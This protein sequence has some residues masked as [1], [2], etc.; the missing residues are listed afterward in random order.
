MDEMRRCPVVLTR[1][2]DWRAEQILVFEALNESDYMANLHLLL[3]SRDRE[4]RVRIGVFPGFP[5]RLA[6]PLAVA[7]GGTLFLERTPGRFKATVGGGNL[8]FAELAE[9]RIDCEDVARD[10]IAITAVA[11]HDTMPDDYPMPAEPLVDELHQWRQRDWPGKASSLGEVRQGLHAELAGSEPAWPGDWSVYGGWQGRKFEATG[12]FRTEHDGRRWWLVDPDGNAFWSAGVDCVRMQ[13]EVNAN[14]LESLFEPPLP[15]RES[16]PELWAGRGFDALSHNLSRTLPDNWQASW[17]E[18]TRRR[19]I[20]FGFNTIGNWS[21]RE[22]QRTAKLPYVFT[23]ADFPSTAQPLFRDFPDVYSEEYTTNCA[24][25]A[26]QLA[27]IRDD[28]HVIGY[29]MTNEPKWAFLTDFD[30]GRQLLLDA[31]PS[32]TRDAFVAFLKAR[33]AGIAEL[34]AAWGCTLSAWDDL[35]RPLDLRPC[36]KSAKDTLA[37][38]HEAVTEYVTRPAAACHGVDPHH[39]NLGLRWA[40]IHHDYQLAGCEVLDLFS[41][42][43]YQLAPPAETIAEL[44]RQTGKPV[45]IG[46]WHIGALDRGLPSGGIRNCA[47]MDESVAAYRYYLEQAA[48]IPELVGAHYFQ[49]TDQH[50]L[51]RFD[52][53]NMQIGLHDITYRPYA[54]HLAALPDIHARAY[55]IAAGQAEPCD[56]PPVTVPWGTLVG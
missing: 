43:C 38:T 28:R 6:I 8:P 21:D 12:W 25:F 54:E 29:F 26:E 42:N 35:A 34:N 2:A 16:A 11:V 10:K 48:A 1:E 23:M 14:G 7:G 39:L 20:G 31:R 56:R 37:F 47:T 5:T 33:H 53:E 22:L 4:V 52:G 45:M 24:R 19:L 36:P 40:W 27:A 32:A 30:L 13:Q 41:I 50:V 49:W 15:S 9:I 46:E 55:R 51:G 44:S 18:L 17:R 3:L